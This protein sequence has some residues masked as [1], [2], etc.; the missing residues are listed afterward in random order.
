MYDLGFLPVL[1]DNAT[2]FTSRI[3]LCAFV[4][5]DQTQRPT[6][7]ASANVDVSARVDA[8]QSFPDRD[9]LMN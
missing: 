4:G 6:R 9:E 3:S 5:D 2:N 8:R 7:P 1:S